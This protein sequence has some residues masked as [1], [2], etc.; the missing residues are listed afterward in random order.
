MR[1]ILEERRRGSLT[2]TVSL[3]RWKRG[4]GLATAP[5]VVL[6]IGSATRCRLAARVCRTPPSAIISNATASSISGQP[7]VPSRPRSLFGPLR[8]SQAVICITHLW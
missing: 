8:D 2:G 4:G 3:E 1:W 5:R 6:V 7:I